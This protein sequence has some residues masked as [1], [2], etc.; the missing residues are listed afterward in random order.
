MAGFSVKNTTKSSVFDLFCPHFCRGCGKIGAI[1]CECCKN[2]V[3]ITK[4]D[5]DLDYDPE[6]LE[7]IFMVGWHDGIIGKLVKEYKYN[8]V[9]AL[10]DVLA[11]FL[12]GALPVFSEEIVLVPLP[13]IT[14]HIRQRGFD[15]IGVL[16]R[17]LAKRRGWKM[18]KCLVRNKNS[19]QVGASGDERRKQ[20]KKA[21]RLNK[22]VDSDKYYLLLDDVWTT[23]ASMREAAT[24]MKKGGAEKIMGVVLAVNR[25][26]D[27]RSSVGR[28]ASE[29]VKDKIDDSVR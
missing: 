23:G 18:E 17:K 12:D 3:S 21:Y 26:K 24:I 6:I 11:E 8:S 19:V 9:R 29:R 15:H 4:M 27:K 10:A 14:S 20:A 28:S 22:K 16:T 2:Y 13:T 1:F 25:G 5:Y 7:K